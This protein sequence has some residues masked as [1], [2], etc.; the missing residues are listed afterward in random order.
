MKVKPV[1]LGGS[2]IAY[3]LAALL[4]SIHQHV[5]MD[6]PRSLRLRWSHVL[7]SPSSPKTEPGKQ[8]GNHPMYLPVSACVHLS[9]CPRTSCGCW[10]LCWA[11]FEGRAPGLGGEKELVQTDSGGENLKSCTNILELSVCESKEKK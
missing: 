1:T 3:N 10:P 4:L 7:F 6:K 2:W 5:H 11:S 9:A 8:L